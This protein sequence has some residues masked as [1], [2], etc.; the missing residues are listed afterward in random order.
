MAENGDRHPR[1]LCRH[2]PRHGAQ[3]VYCCCA[4]CPGFN[5]CSSKQGEQKTPI[6]EK[7]HTL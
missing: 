4:Y 5:P 3:C 1:H 2:H 6:E 7:C